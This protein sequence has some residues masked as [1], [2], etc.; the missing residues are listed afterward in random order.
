MNSAWRRYCSRDSARSASPNSSWSLGQ[1]C[2]NW[3]SARRRRRSPRRRGRRAPSSFVEHFGAVW[4]SMVRRPS[5]SASPES[6]AAS[7]ALPENVDAPREHAAGR[8]ANRSARPVRPASASPACLVTSRRKHRVVE[9][10]HELQPQGG[11]V[12]RAQ[13]RNAVSRTAWPG[14]KSG[15]SR[16]R[17]RSAGPNRRSARSRRR[18]PGTDRAPSRRSALRLAPFRPVVGQRHDPERTPRRVTQTRRERET[19]RRH[20]AAGN[21]AARR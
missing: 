9:F 7:V 15:P 11:Q 12:R 18:S 10:F 20:R 21:S 3:A 5:G 6:G 1:T 8:R 4:R 16:A 19:G 17:A 2:R 13:A 14:T